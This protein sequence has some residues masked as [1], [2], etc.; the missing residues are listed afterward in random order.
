VRST[1]RLSGCKK[2]LPVSTARRRKDLHAIW[3]AVFLCGLANREALLASYQ[4]TCD[5]FARELNPGAFARLRT[6][7]LWLQTDT[8]WLAIVRLGVIIAVAIVER[9]VVLVAWLAMPQVKKAICRVI[10]VWFVV[11]PTAKP[12]WRAI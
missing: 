6:S 5:V 9:D 12:P 4:N 10:T 2:G 11:A 7:R 1:Q 3:A 8:D